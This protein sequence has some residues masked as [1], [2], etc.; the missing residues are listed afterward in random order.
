MKEF[1]IEKTEFT[2]T[3]KINQCKVSV[4]W[5]DDQERQTSNIRK[6]SFDIVSR[7]I[8]ETINELENWGIYPD[9]FTFSVTIKN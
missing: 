2:E 3:I 9:E 5:K 7:K 6:E 4:L 8:K 1:K